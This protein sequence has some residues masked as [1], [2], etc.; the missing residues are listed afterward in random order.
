MVFCMDCSTR[1]HAKGKRT[2][3]TVVEITAEVA[4]AEVALA[5]AVAEVMRV[6][7]EEGKPTLAFYQEGSDSGVTYSSTHTSVV[8]P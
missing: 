6:V 7:E 2:A 8:E 4:V 3:H 5:M 1:S